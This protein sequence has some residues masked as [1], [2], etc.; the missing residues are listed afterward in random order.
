M[1]SDLAENT[2]NRPFFVVGSGWQSS[3][4]HHMG[5]T[6]GMVPAAAVG[7]MASLAHEIGELGCRP[8]LWIRPWYSTHPDHVPLVL[9][10]GPGDAAG[11]GGVLDPT[12]PDTLDMIR[13]DVAVARS[14]GFSMIRHDHSTLD[15]I[16]RWGAPSSAPHPVPWYDLRVTT[17]EV[18]RTLYRTIHE[19]AGDDTLISACGSAGRLAAGHAHVQRAS[20]HLG[21]R[22]W[23]QVRSVGINGLAFRGFQQGLLYAVEAG[24]V[25]L[26][27]ATP[28]AL[29]E[30]WLRLLAGSGT[31]FFVSARH[32]ALNEAEQAA[33][34]AAFTRASRPT[35]VAEP[36]DWLVSTCPARW[37]MGKDIVSF[38][39]FS[40][41]Y[42]SGEGPARQ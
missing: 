16:G 20:S 35:P 27:D 26:S 12:H 15:L 36:M 38:D 17:A 22:T 24:S 18:L 28:W 4:G 13:R 32:T 21:V 10:S 40:G 31:P 41:Q 14:W 5:G 23:E 39:W 42:A 30:Q 29:S 19:A 2:V 25:Y 34:R 3:S 11:S 9:R 1:A 33:V 7:D 37:Q 6:A 8:G